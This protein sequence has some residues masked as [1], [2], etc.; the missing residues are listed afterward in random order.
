MRTYAKTQVTAVAVI[1]TGALGLG[2][3]TASANAQEAR[4]DRAPR[5]AVA[6]LDGRSVDLGTSWEGADVC[7]VGAAGKV[8]CW[9]AGTAATA[10]QKAEAAARKK[11]KPGWFCIWDGTNFRGRMLKFNEERWHNLAPYGFSNRASSAQNRQ[12]DPWPLKDRAYLADGRNG[13][14]KQR[15]FEEGDRYASLGRFN[16]KASSVHG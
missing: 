7:E 5:G 9:D 8:T 2:A 1:V 3:L 11:C 16:N 10:T 6:T 4:P 14:G 13:D 12:D 15:R